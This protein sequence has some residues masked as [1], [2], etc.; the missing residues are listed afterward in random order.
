MAAMRYYG[1]IMTTTI[2]RLRCT[3]AVADVFYIFN[4]TVVDRTCFFY[5]KPEGPLPCSEETP[6][7]PCPETDQPSPP[8]PILLL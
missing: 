2:W 1:N 7:F 3:V 6:S 5:M 4:S 8:P